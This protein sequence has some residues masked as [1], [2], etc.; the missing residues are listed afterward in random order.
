V[1]FLMI[2]AILA[3]HAQK[4]PELPSASVEL[5]V[6]L[7]DGKPLVR[8]AI[9]V[10]VLGSSPFRAPIPD[11]A[12]A[13]DDQGVARFDIPAGVYSLSVTV[14]K[15]GYGSV[16]A[17]EFIADKVTRPS[18]PA[19]AAYGSVDVIVPRACGNDFTIFLGGERHPLPPDASNQLHFDDLVA[20][21]SSVEA[22][23]KSDP[24][25]WLYD[26]CSDVATVNII[27]GQNI[28]IILR[29]VPA[30]LNIPK[31]SDPNTPQ[32]V[33][34]GGDHLNQEPVVW[35][36]GTVRDEQ[37]HPIV[38]GTVYAVATTSGS[39]RMGL[40][41]EAKTDTSGNYEVKGAPR[42]IGPSVT[43][44][45]TAPGHPPSWAWLELN[46]SAA[47]NSPSISATQ[48]LVLPSNGSSANIT[49]LRGGKP[50]AGAAVALYL[51]NASL[52]DVWA[53]GGPNKAVQDF[54]YPV[55]TTDAQGVARFDELLPGRY[56]VLA[57]TQRPEMIRQPGFGLER[58]GGP[59]PSAS[60]GGIPVQIGQTTN[61]RINIY[62]QSN[63]A[64]FRVFKS[65]NTP[66]TGTGADRFGPVDTVVLS[67]SASLD[68]TGLG[69]LTFLQHTGFWRLD[70]M[71]R[72]SPITAFPIYPPYFQSSGI[73]ALSPN[74]AGI[75]PPVFTAHAVE[76][77]SARIVVQDS[78][79]HPIHATVQIMRFSSLAASGT[80]DDD[81]VVLFKGLY[82]G[83]QVGSL[84]DQYFVRIRSTNFVNEAFTDL[85]KG[86][87]PLPTP[88]LL[89]TRQ[90]FMDQKLWAQRLP[91]SVD[92][93]TTLVV[94]A[95]RL[96]YVYGTIHSSI[97][98]IYGPS[99][100]EW[101]KQGGITY[102]AALRVL[103]GG[104][105]VAGPFLPGMVD[106]GFWDSSSPH[107]VSV[108]IELDANP[109]EPLRFDFD[110]DKYSTPPTVVENKP[111]P[112]TDS[113]LKSGGESYLGMTGITTHITGA[114]HFAGQVFLAD[115]KTPAFGAQVLYY[116]AGSTQPAFF[117]IT[118]ARGNL[119]PRR[120]WRSASVVL[121]AP[122]SSS[123]PTL[124]AFLPGA[125]GATIQTS[126]VRPDDQVRLILPR[127]IS[128][129]GRV[130]VGALAPYNRPGSIHILAAYQGKTPY[131]SALS[132]TT[133]ADADGHFTL[134]GLTPGT[135]IIQASLD[136]IWLSQQEEVRLS[137]T[138]KKLLT[139]SIP[140]PGAPLHIKLV[141]SVG[142]PVSGKSITIDRTGPLSV[143][144]PSQ[145]TSD[146]AGAIYIPTLEAG[147]HNIRVPGS[148]TPLTVDIPKLP[149]K[150]A[151]IQ[152]RVDHPPN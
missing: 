101:E 2:A 129:T 89:H 41:I 100:D 28:K 137:A 33:T 17:T 152:I 63:D 111:E 54:A 15:I 97:K 116:D 133:T 102:L 93:Q 22:A 24:I 106:L 72:D 51:E 26:P 39:V 25:A 60:A 95:E 104:E 138:R 23:S 135:Y 18:M 71:F 3:A 79:G 53:A 19:L 150:A 127:P 12:V 75:D 118:D 69:H 6:Q 34:I 32:T 147:R 96:R 105:Y 29:P 49:V 58:P 68:S 92:K 46:Q 1:L 113:Q 124:I 86:D 148:S 120:L 47:Q 50:V 30:D 99:L 14:H 122:I 90:A 119:H 140:L 143:L 38:N 115:G 44:L 88:Q 4:S 114:S 65:D 145:W 94:R 80:T 55:A 59:G 20:G 78:M 121:G 42:L 149:A 110:A 132:V 130:T 56:R 76:P 98:P 16:G 146:S 45:A 81:G 5:S 62:S 67:S 128:L 27:G 141:N 7:P 82:N 131:D 144:W 11:V 61:F 35:V 112:R 139:L 37:G 10:R 73:V 83:D 91:L 36:R 142:D 8:T 40:T 13:T 107:F 117:G 136:D 9:V 84:S 85:G 151:Q 31:R 125:C 43:L 77:G 134:A 123:T 21:K 48:D 126:P 64:S 70:F 74:L 57:T 103:P 109:D 87:D 66:Y 108:P 52:Q